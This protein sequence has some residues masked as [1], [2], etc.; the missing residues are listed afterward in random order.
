M[1]RKVTPHVEG[2]SKQERQ[3]IR[4]QLGP[5]K[6]LTVQPRTRDRYN[7]ALAKFFSYLKERDCQLPRQRAH[8]DGVVADYLEFL[9]QAGE[10]RALA[11]DTLAVSQDR[12]PAV[13]GFLMG[14]WRLLKTWMANELPNRAPP[15]TEEAFLHTLAGHALFRHQPV[16]ALS[17][18]LGFYGLLRT[19]ELL[20][21]RNKDVSQ[22]TSSSVAVISLGLTKGGKRS[23]AAESVTISEQETLRSLWQWK[24]STAPGQLLAAPVEPHGC[25]ASRGERREPLEPGGPGR[26]GTFRWRSQALVNMNRIS[27]ACFTAFRS[28]SSEAVSSW[29]RKLEAKAT[30]AR[31]SVR[32][33]PEG[34]GWSVPCEHTDSRWT[35]QLWY[36]WRDPQPVGVSID[37]LFGTDTLAT[38]EGLKDAVGGFLG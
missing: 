10:G 13:K 4:K 16:F 15:L 1:G 7:K 33:P 30:F 20:S 35:M 32:V 2:R 6:S 19:G 28:T 11:S 37:A 36:K 23:G 14:S 17:L 25:A 26:R 3:A 29:L 5:L 18:L 8:L 34:E 27:A 12:D 9:W 38:R 24:K 31:Q 21:I 22:A